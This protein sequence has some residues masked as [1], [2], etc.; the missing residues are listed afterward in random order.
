MEKVKAIIFRLVTLPIGIVNMAVMALHL[1]LVKWTVGLYCGFGYE[2]DSIVWLATIAEK[3]QN[4][5]ANNMKV[6][7]AEVVKELE[8]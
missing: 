1:M 6:D 4:A 8:S 7:P 5:M 2:L 3:Y